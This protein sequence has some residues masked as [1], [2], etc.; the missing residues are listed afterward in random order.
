MSIQLNEK[1]QHQQMLPFF[2]YNL[3]PV[4]LNMW[5][6]SPSSGAQLRYEDV[7]LSRPF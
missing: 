4:A 7:L 2:G 6:V 3:P 5:S 1:P